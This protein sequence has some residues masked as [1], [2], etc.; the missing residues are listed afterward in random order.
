MRNSVTQPI[1][2]SG[3]VSHSFFYYIKKDMCRQT[4]INYHMISY[5]QNVTRVIKY[6]I[7]HYLLY[8]K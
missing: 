2:K 4:H 1:S 3:F 6:S 8:V 5:D 7:L